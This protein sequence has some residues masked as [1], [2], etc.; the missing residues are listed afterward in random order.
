MSFPTLWAVAINLLTAQIFSAEPFL[1]N[2]AQLGYLSAGPTVGGLLGSIAA[3]AISDP[4]IKFMARRNKGVYE[5]E[6]R[7]VLIIP[8]FVLSTIGY[9]LFGALVEAGKSPAAMAVLWG[10]TVA[11][12]QFM[13]MAVGTYCVDAY[14]TISVE[15]FI[16]T[17]VIKN[18][19]F[20]GFSCEFP[21]HSRGRVFA[22]D[23]F[24]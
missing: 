22:N 1:L 21:S 5:P 2:T 11:A 12:I 15:I 6:Y 17:M 18:F 7:L 13:I 9:F 3:A 20:Y 24:V 16:S 14:R 10:I 19:L 4:F 23:A 8:A